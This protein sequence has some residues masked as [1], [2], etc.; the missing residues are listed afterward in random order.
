MLALPHGYYIKRDW[1]RSVEKSSALNVPL[2]R[3]I[4]SVPSQFFYILLPYGIA[5]LYR[6]EMY[7]VQYS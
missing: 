4:S 6:I 5:R 3:L 2:F 1:K 7:I